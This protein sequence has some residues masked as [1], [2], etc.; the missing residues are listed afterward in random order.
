MKP[1]PPM[2]HKI[3]R[4][5][6]YWIEACDTDIRIRFDAEWTRIRREAEAKEHQ[7]ISILRVK[8]K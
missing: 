8:R 2:D 5:N 7:I 6:G 4:P 1:P 3:H